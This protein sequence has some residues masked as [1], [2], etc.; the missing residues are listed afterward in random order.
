MGKKDYATIY[1]DP[2]VIK[3]AKELGLNIS[4]TCENALKEAIRRLEGSNSQS[5]LETGSGSSQK[6]DGLVG[7]E[8][9]ELSAFGSHRSRTSSSHRSGPRTR[10]T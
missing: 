3:K 10:I 9:F 4:K 5:S 7:P 2:E 1:V 8:R 6:N